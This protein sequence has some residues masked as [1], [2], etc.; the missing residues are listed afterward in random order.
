MSTPIDSAAPTLAP[1]SPTIPNYETASLGNDQSKDSLVKIAPYPFDNVYSDADVVLQ[2]ADGTR[3]YLHKA[4]LRIASAFF[5]DMFSLPQPLSPDSP[6]AGRAEIPT[7]PVTEDSETFERLLYTCYRVDRPETSSI[8]A[9]TLAHV[10][11][12]ALKYQMPIGTAMMSKSLSSRIHMTPLDVFAVAYQL[13][14]EDMVEEAVCE[15][16]R[17]QSGHKAASRGSKPTAEKPR[18]AHPLDEYSVGM[19]A[20]PAGVYYRLLQHHAARTLESLRSSTEAAVRRIVSRPRDTEK[21]RGTEMAIGRLPHPF[22]DTAHAD[23][24]IRSSDNAVFYVNRSLLSFASPV[25]AKSLSVSSTTTGSGAPESAPA[26]PTFVATHRFP[27]DGRTLSKLFQ[28]SYPMPDPELTETG[29]ADTRLK[30]AL[31]VLAAA[32][33]YEVA[34]A[35]A[36]A[37]R[38]CVEAAGASPV[39]LY[40]LATQYNWDDV[41]KDA[42][43]RSV[44]ETSDAYYP[45]MESAS[46]VAYRRLLVYCRKCRDVIL[47]GGD[48]A[49]ETGTPVVHSA[50]WSQSSW[51]RPRSVH[52]RRGISSKR[53]PR[54]V[55]LAADFC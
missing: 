47:R 9:H 25:L 12:A 20:L 28:L 41:A 34:R 21:A 52:G 19:D 26:S 39:R 45:E 49:Q 1:S 23:T 16:T 24:V 46:A 2:T 4:V 6:V 33:K 48:A 13:N 38:A 40:L 14:L 18:R 42:A 11:S 17:W 22:Y 36:F 32:K 27:E 51:L 37:K 44:Y 35:V 54:C 10:L 50:Y 7:I 43:M 31:S 5:A 15:F 55:G 3:F 8:E 30:D 29:F 53:R